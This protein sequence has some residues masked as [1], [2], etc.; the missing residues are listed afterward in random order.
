MKTKNTLLTVLLITLF[1]LTTK[2]QD[3]RFKA[4][5]FTD[6]VAT[7]TD[8]FNIGLGIEY[9]MSTVYFKAQTF[10]FPDLR[11]F[12]YTELTG[13]PLGFNYHDRFRDFR[14]YTGLKLGVILR[15]NAP[16]PTWGG[17]IGIEFYTNGDSEGFSFG[18][19]GSLDRRTD[20]KIHDVDIMPYW[21]GSGF[22]VV[23]W[24][25]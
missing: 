6:P 19:M 22:A 15:D 1:T 7:T 13:V 14:A 25:F 17:E 24:S 5:T 3:V 8:G 20:G 11:G 10:I 4:F 9:Q 16:H 2:A 23:G 18:L 12:T 21:R